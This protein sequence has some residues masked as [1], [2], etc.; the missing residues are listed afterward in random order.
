MGSGIVNVRERERARANTE[1]EGRI[2]ARRTE[3]IR[4]RK[5]T[6]GDTD[7][8]KERERERE[9]EGENTVVSRP[10]LLALFPCSEHLTCCLTSYPRTEK[11]SGLSNFFFFFFSLFTLHSAQ[12]LGLN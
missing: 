5:K 4:E 7:R 6:I 10:L 11:N 2:K 12:L 8:E 1:G 9:R 3:K